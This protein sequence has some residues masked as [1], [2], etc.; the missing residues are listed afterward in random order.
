VAQLGVDDFAFR[1]GHRYGTLLYDHERHCVV[2]LLPDRTTATLAQW[3]REH[4]GVEIVTRDRADAYAEGIRQGAPSA[5]QVADRWHIVKNLG[6]AL[7]RLLDDKRSLIKQA[8]QPIPPSETEEPASPAQT[9]AKPTHHDTLKQRHRQ[10]RLERYE[11]VRALWEQ[12]F[13]QGAIAQ[14]MQLDPHT[15]RKFLRAQAF[16]ERKPRVPSRQPGVLTPYQRYLRCRWVH[17]CH[18][19][20]QL[21]QEVIERGY[22]GSYTTV[23]DFVK[24]LRQPGMSRSRNACPLVRSSLGYS[25]AKRIVPTSRPVF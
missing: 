4:P 7:E 16:P 21:W 23:K 9:P 6:Q 3:L 2:D 11:Q 25:N 10:Q 8:I 20:R 17:G 13:N 14:Q 19:A 5:K 1:R 15:I 24:Q 18:N 12:G 22:S